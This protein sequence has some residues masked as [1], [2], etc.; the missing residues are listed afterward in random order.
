[1][2]C[3]YEYVGGAGEAGWVNS[4][5]SLG[6]GPVRLGGVCNLRIHLFTYR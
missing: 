3:V 5:N 4:N 2:A 1:M 6:V